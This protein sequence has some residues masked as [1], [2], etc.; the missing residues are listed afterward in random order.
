MSYLSRQLSNDESVIGE[1][2]FTFKAVISDFIACGIFIA[3]GLYLLYR[4]FVV[5]N[6][7]CFIIGFV[8]ILASIIDALKAIIKIKTTVLVYTEKR[9]IG[10]TGL[11]NIT[12][13]ASPLNKINNVE[14]QQGLWGRILG[15]GKIE[16]HTSSKDYYYKGIEKPDEF[17]LKVME[18]IEISENERIKSQAEQL[19][20]TM[21]QNR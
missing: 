10:K 1:A 21:I 20:K 17:R 12:A 8:L 16:I 18:Q 4:F 13:L 14:V 5:N 3:I 9:I 2:H 15:Y 6:L 7:W 11:I 19:A